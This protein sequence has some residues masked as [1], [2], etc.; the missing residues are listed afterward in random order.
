MTATEIILPDDQPRELVAESANLWGSSNPA[1]VVERATA[2]SRAL[3]DVVRS[4]K[5]SVQI[6][7]NG[8]SNEYLLI[9]AWTMLGSMVGLFPRVVWTK[10]LEVDGKRAGWEARVEVVTRDGSVVGAAESM[11]TRDESTKKRDGAVLHRWADA[12]EHAVR[13][14]AQT[15]ATSKA[16]ATCLRFVAVLAGFAGTPAEE[17][18]RDGAG[19]TGRR[20]TSRRAEYPK[21][22]LG[23]L[24][25]VC[26]KEGLTSTTGAPPTI[27]KSKQGSMQCNG[28]TKD[29]VKD[30]ERGWM[31]HP[32]PLHEGEEVHDDAPIPFT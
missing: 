25:G 6:W 14:M 3:M 31:N 16:L 27:R 11:C 26:A 19:Q 5:L 32:E 17:M 23:S 22:G 9:E 15:R 1:V 30:G 7:A 4:Q 28:R 12:D 20:E 2:V 8:K 21:S 24:C 18:P 29:I 13:S 10:P